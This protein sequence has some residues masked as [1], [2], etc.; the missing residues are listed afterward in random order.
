LHLPEQAVDAERHEISEARRILDRIG[1]LDRRNGGSPALFSG[2]EANMARQ[3]M[4]PE[5]RD[6]IVLPDNLAGERPRRRNNLA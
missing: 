1:S 6:L 5:P 3:N 2:A 4:A